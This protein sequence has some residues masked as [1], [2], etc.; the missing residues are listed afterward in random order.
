MERFAFLVP[1][2]ALGEQVI[3]KTD[4]FDCGDVSVAKV[5][6]DSRCKKRSAGIET[7]REEYAIVAF[8]VKS[9]RRDV[10]LRLVMA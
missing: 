5:Y 7:I 6:C 8:A 4:S 1:E 10:P 2:S 9:C 3:S